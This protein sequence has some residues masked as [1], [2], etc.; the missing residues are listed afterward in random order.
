MKTDSRVVAALEQRCRQRDDGQLTLRCADAFAL[1]EELAIP[2][3]DVG[4]ICD[5]Q[6]VKIV[7]CQIGCFS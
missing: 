2:L 6:G 7:H 3:S 4:R 5:E 1:A